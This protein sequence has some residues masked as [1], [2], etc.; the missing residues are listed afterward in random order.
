MAIKR[1]GQAGFSLIEL[2]ITLAILSILLSFAVVSFGAQIDRSQNRKISNSLRASIA[3]TRSESIARGGNVRFCGSSNGTACATS[4]DDGWVIYHDT[5]ADGDLTAADTV[6]TWYEQS[7][8]GL[9]IAGADADDAAV[10]DIGFNYRGYPTQAISLAVSGRS[11]DSTV[12]VF[13]NGRVEIS[14]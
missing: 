9:T 11:V 10:A 2:M 13:A 8:N 4:F 5:N 3:Q 1:E 12:Q 7:Y 14:E 6:L